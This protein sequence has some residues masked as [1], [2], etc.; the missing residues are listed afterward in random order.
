[1]FPALGGLL[2]HDLPQLLV[3]L[4]IK[5]INKRPVVQTSHLLA[6]DTGVP[7]TIGVAPVLQMLLHKMAKR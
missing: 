6:M 3:R 2:A 7:T 4:K 1:V 5:R